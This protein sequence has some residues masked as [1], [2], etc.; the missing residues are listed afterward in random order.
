[1]ATT[2]H[3]AVDRNVNWQDGREAYYGFG[4]SFARI[5]WGA[6]LAGALVAL[7][8]QLVLTLIGGA[9]GLATLDP[10]TGDSPNGAT[11]GIGAA[12]WLVVS[13][14]IALFVGGYV[15][16]RLGGTFNGWLHG[17]ATWATVT[18]LTLA[19][20]ATAA[21]G[22]IGAAS[23]LSAFAVSNSDR[24]SRTQLPPTVQQ[25]IDQLTS[26]ARQSADQAATQ[27]RQTTP[28]QRE[29][30]ARKLGQ[31]AA[32]GGAAGTGAAALALILGALAA[33]VGGRVGHRVPL[34][35]TET[36]VEEE[37]RT[38]STGKTWPPA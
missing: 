28:E 37:G 25:Q 16:G 12:I 7:A 22:L 4:R 14:L 29:A 26:Q 38:G 2:N 11:L 17:L 33:A 35:D 27:V 19:L 3:I 21:G 13:S 5:S 24:T 18:A 20:L 36:V 6:I 8:T 1:M 31:R 32:K 10:A 9:I 30:A 23:G 34:R 15:A